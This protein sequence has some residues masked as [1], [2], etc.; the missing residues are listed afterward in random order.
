MPFQY[1]LAFEIFSNQLALSALPPLPSDP[2]APLKPCYPYFAATEL[3]ASSP[4][5][6]HQHPTATSAT[7]NHPAERGNS[8]LGKTRTKS[9]ARAE[10][11]HLGSDSSSVTASMS[12]NSDDKSP[13]NDSRFCVIRIE[14]Y[15]VVVRQDQASSNVTEMPPK[16]R[17]QRP[18]DAQ[19]VIASTTP[20]V[21]SSST[22]STSQSSSRSVTSTSKKS[23]FGGPTAR[24][25]PQHDGTAEFMSGILHLYRDAKECEVSSHDHAEDPST[26]GAQLRRKRADSQ[27]TS[28]PLGSPSFNSDKSK[29]VVKDVDSGTLVCVLAVPTYMS[30]SDFLSFIGYHQEHVSHFRTIH[31]HLPNRYMVLMRFRDAA[32]ARLF[33]DQYN[34]RQFSVLEPELCHVVHIRSIVFKSTS[35]PPFAFPHDV[36]LPEVDGVRLANDHAT[37]ISPTESSPLYE[38]PTC[39][40]CLERMDSSTSGIF[41]TLCQHTFHCGCLSRWGQNESTCPVC[42]HSQR[43]MAQKHRQ[44]TDSGMFSGAASDLDSEP[45]ECAVCGA[46]DNLWICL[47]CG[48][49]GCGR[50]EG[51]HAQQ[52]FVETSHLYA[53][54]I[55]SQRVWDYAGD[56]YV[57]R[58]IQNKADGKLVEIPA[59]HDREFRTN[60]KLEAITKEYTYLLTTQLDAQRQF[61]E[62]RLSHVSTQIEALQ[63]QCALMSTQMQEHAAERKA[64]ERKETELQDAIRQQVDAK[65]AAEQKTSKCMQL[66]RNIQKELKEEQLMSSGLLDRTEQL[67]TQVQERDSTVADLQE[68]LRD[69][70][71]FLDA[72]QKIEKSNMREEIQDGTIS[73]NVGNSSN[74]S[75]KGGRGGGRKGKKRS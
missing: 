3:A 52:H 61:Y 14:S 41:T 62:S 4:A 43:Q 50:Y 12:N 51:A 33:H 54:E 36:W 25:V 42:R 40:V 65:L 13:V 37:A 35:L 66:L 58:L 18:S 16:T 56:G 59:P 67:K 49:I 44:D 48:N 29:E 38:L 63:A 1:T 31:D 2:F 60:E 71:F 20:T 7:S 72:Q 68:Q 47:L 53:L 21:Q 8:Y 73:V 70:M 17:L 69:L 22:A 28:T 75:S 10:S 24:F 55:E 32:N 19:Q 11:T 34:E 15:T 39:P 27:S 9:L 26:E 6:V 46:A 45:N 64:W 23:V 30:P 5:P 57:H 74:N